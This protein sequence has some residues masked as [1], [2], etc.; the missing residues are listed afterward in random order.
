[1]LQRT[2]RSLALRRHVPYPHSR[3]AVN[4]LA[5]S[6]MHPFN[7]HITDAVCGMKANCFSVCFGGMG[8]CSTFLMLCACS[9]CALAS[10]RVV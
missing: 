8:T 9:R 1:M 5:I 10:D 6:H 3:Q 4:A 2:S 7:A